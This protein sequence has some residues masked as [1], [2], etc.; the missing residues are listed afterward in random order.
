MSVPR[1]TTD[2]EGTAFDKGAQLG[3]RTGANTSAIITNNQTNATNRR[4]NACV[5]RMSRIHAVGAFPLR[6]RWLGLIFFLTSAGDQVLRQ[7]SPLR[8]FSTRHQGHSSPACRAGK[9]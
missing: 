2:V 1:M 7:K 8:H 9:R 3:C 4:S 6:K 5:P